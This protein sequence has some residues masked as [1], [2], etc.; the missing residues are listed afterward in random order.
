MREFVPGLSRV[1]V[2]WDASMDRSPLHAAETASRAIGIQLQTFAIRSPTEFG[3]TIEAAAKAHSGAVMVIQSPLMDVRGAEIAALALER[4]LPAVG[5]VASFAK[6]GGLV[7][8]G[9]DVLELFGNLGSLV[10]RIVKGAR[11]GELPIER[12][13]KLYLTINL[14]RRK[15]SA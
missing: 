3:A 10:D 11:P 9:P 12:P 2:L 1:A 13:T 8:Y 15:R 14:R 6:Q 5:L 7:S 4:R